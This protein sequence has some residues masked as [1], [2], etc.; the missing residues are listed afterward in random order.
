MTET[1]DKKRTPKAI[2][3]NFQYPVRS[4]NRKSKAVTVFA[5]ATLSVLKNEP[6]ELSYEE[7]YDL[8]REL[9]RASFAEESTKR[10]EGL[11]DAHTRY[12][13]EQFKSN[14][15]ESM[16]FLGQI[17]ECWNVFCGQLAKIFALYLEVEKRYV[18]P[19]QK[20]FSIWRLGIEKFRHYFSSDIIVQRRTVSEILKLIE[21]ERRGLKIDRSLVKDLLSM[22][23]TLSLYSDIFEP[24]FFKETHLIYKKDS[25]SLIRQVEV[26]EYLKYIQKIINDENTRA[27]YYLDNITRNPLIQTIE[28]ELIANH[29]NT[30]L[31]KGLDQMLDDLRMDDLRLLYQLLS[32]VPDGLA[33]MCLHFNKYIKKRGLV[34]ITDAEKD[35]TMVQELLE[36][37]E[38]MDQVLEDCFSKEERF[39]YTVKEAFEHFINQRQNKPAELIAKF[40]DSK[41]KSG[42]KESSEDELERILNKILVLFRFIHGKDVF[43]AFYKKDLAKRLL[44]NKSASVDAEK[45]MLSKLKQ[46]CGAAFTSKLE[47]MFKDIELS[48][49]MMTNFRHY[50]ASQKIVSPIDMSVSVLTMGYWPTY[51]PVDVI[52]PD[53]LLKHQEAFKNF[54]T[55]KYHGRKLQWQPNLG[56]CT[57]IGTFISPEGNDNKTRRH[58]LI[59]SLYQA[60]VLLLFNDKDELTYNEILESTKIES[61]ELRRTLQSLACGKFR[62]LVKEPKGKDINDGDKFIYFKHFKCALYK[63]KIN[64]VQLKETLEEHSMTEE[65][66]FQDRQYQID[67]AIVRI[68]K[69]RKKLTHNNLSTEVFEHLKFPVRA[70]DLKVRIESLIERDYLSRSK[71]NPMEYNYVT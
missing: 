45:S 63:I 22:L 33:E 13:L 3:K 9:F 61:V 35:K 50:L 44:V 17:N 19:E 30:I 67:A 20:S 65:R 71:D 34:I 23:S 64:Q 48:Q 15:L 59:V 70:H 66:I 43:E 24:E 26:P 27:M 29:I 25:E 40:I 38:K 68:M 16:H 39:L 57:L 14:D 28:T 1:M 54:Y 55:T 46:E 21:Q 12:I 10:V 69:T 47:G 5:D 41:L 4:R 6:S 51:Q 7:L 18:A 2:C 8:S 11:I 62:V 49:D 58:E 53:F 37:K 32:R 31:T 52:V 42:N 36:F 60:L 56:H